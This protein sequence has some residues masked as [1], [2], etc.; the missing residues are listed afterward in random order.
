MF[1]DNTGYQT[2]RFSGEMRRQLDRYKSLSLLK[3]AQ[4]LLLYLKHEVHD[5]E[6]LLQVESRILHCSWMVIVMYFNLVE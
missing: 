4:S 3:I 5:K 6:N 1:E 2:S